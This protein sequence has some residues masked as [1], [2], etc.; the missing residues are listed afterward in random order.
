MQ[1]QDGRLRPIASLSDLLRGISLNVEY[2]ITDNK[3]CQLLKI[4][5]PSFFHYGKKYEDF[6]LIADAL[7]DIG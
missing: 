2:Y 7:A 3:N 4:L 5:R 1:G 6:Y